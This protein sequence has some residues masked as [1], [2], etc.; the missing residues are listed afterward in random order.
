MSQG[1]R[2]RLR[3]L[4]LVGGLVLGL[5]LAEAGARLLEPGGSLEGLSSEIGERIDDPV[6]DYRT[7]PNTGQNDAAGYRNPEALAQA[8]VVALGD[9]QTWGVNAEMDET[10]P[11][12]L[13]Q[14]TGQR[15]YNMGR[16]GYGIVQYRYQLE[17]AL[18]LRPDWVVV[19]LY[20][21]NDIYDAYSLVYSR[22]AHASLRNPDPSLRARIE[23]SEFPDLQGMF[24]ER[25]R[26]GREH[27]DPESWLTRHSALARMITRARGLP[28]DVG[29]DRA[30][31]RDHPE[32]GFVY[33]DGRVSTVFHSSYRLVA[34]DSRL[35]RI[36]EG[37]RITLWELEEMQDR[38]QA[39]AGPRMLVVLVPTKERVFA[40][41]IEEAGVPAPESYERS[42]REEARI[43][44][45]L[46]GA[47]QELGIPH[48]DLLP[49]LEQSVA[50][51][52]RIFP[53]NVDGHFTPLGYRRIAE[54]VARA[55]EAA[56]DGARP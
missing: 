34:V 40:R 16:G 9:S 55:L 17:D 30:W 47:M 8:E 23:A 29:A 3:L 31:A 21:G 52:E 1:H 38:V 54:S 41:A 25:V 42:V 43:A 27:G 22:E 18:R 6:L 51:G 7:R 13:E 11:A 44:S 10:W 45:G 5:A 56:D 49:D 53:P 20:L 14:L 37:L 15:V 50:R 28:A 33:D 19:A 35:P 48:V 4:A 12:R 32:D 36:R 2:T 39:A 46:A 26:Y 24:F